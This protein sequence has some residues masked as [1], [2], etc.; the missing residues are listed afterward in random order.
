MTDFI[1]VHTTTD[2]KEA[3]QTIAEAVVAKR[4]AACAHVSGP[5]IN[6]YWWQ[7][8]IE[9]AQEWR[10]IAK[11]TRVCYDDLEQAIRENHT[12]ETP[13]ITATPIITGNTRY[14]DWIEAETMLEP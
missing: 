14:L 4:L 8:K 1:E 7:G 13:E 12:Y 11:T 9:Q 5:L 2:S 3:A 10:C 6:T